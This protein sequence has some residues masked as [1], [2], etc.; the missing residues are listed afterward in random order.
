VVKRR[1]TAEPDGAPAKRPRTV[2]GE[3]VAERKPAAGKRTA[4]PSIAEQARAAIPFESEQPSRSDGEV[5][6]RF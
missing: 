5:L 1:A 3:V 4:A 6:S 2:H